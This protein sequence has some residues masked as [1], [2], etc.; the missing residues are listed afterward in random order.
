M[1]VLYNVIDKE[2]YYFCDIH[3]KIMTDNIMP[4]TIIPEHIRI[5]GIL[6]N[7][8]NIYKIYVYKYNIKKA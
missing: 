3:F 6:Y 2:F 8:W 4:D 1:R 7:F 5:L